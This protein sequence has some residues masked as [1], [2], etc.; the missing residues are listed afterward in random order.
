MDATIDKSGEGG[1][2]SL[3][4]DDYAGAEALLN[5]LNDQ[6]AT[7]EPSDGLDEESKEVTTA[8]K[9]RKQ[10]DEPCDEDPYMAYIAKRMD[11]KS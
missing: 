9:K 7:G 10:C 2:S 4:D 6:D 11:G 1:D 3:T 8:T 5:I